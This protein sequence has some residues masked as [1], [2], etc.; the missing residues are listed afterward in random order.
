M[1]IEGIPSAGIITLINW[2]MMPDGGRYL[3]IWA[4]NWDIITD[5]TMPIEKFHSSEQWQLVGRVNGKI[6]CLIPGC[7]VKAWVSCP[8]APPA[9]PDGQ[10]PYVFEEL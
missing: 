8:T 7:Q 10:R 5:K 2:T 1:M 9:S 6:V 4:P 3:Y